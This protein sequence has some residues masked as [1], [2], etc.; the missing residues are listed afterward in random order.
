MKL[1]KKLQLLCTTLC[2]IAGLGIAVAQANAGTTTTTAEKGTLTPTKVGDI[3]LSVYDF[4]VNNLHIDTKT[5]NTRTTPYWYK[6]K[7]EKD[8][9]IRIDMSARYLKTQ[10]A[11]ASG[12]AILWTADATS[13]PKVSFRI[14]RDETAWYQVSDAYSA[15]GNTGSNMTTPIALDKGEYYLA[16]DISDPS[17]T[18]LGQKGTTGNV[19]MILYQQEINSDEVYRP[20]TINNVN[21]VVIDKEYTG[22][23]TASNPKDFY[24]FKLTEKA[25]VK[26]NCY[27]SATKHSGSS[28]NKVYFTLMDDKQEKLEQK[29]FSGDKQWYSSEKYLEPGTYYY[30]LETQSSYQSGSMGSA[31]YTDGGETRFKITTTSYPLTL[32]KVG[33]TKNTYVKVTTIDDAKEIRVVKGKLSN[34]DLESQKWGAAQIITDTKK[35]GVNKT[36]WYTVRVEDEYGNKFMNSIKISSCD[37]TAPA[38][39]KVNKYKAGALK[40]TG[41]AEKNATITVTANGVSFTCKASSKGKFTCKLTGAFS[42]GTK[43]TVT[44]TDISGNKSAKASFTV[45]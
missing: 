16:L 11:K 3:E 38:K 8:S 26:F 22:V 25:L 27:Y 41:T 20:S 37:K 4:N 2:L 15:Q 6:I 45:K 5:N 14:Y 24:S 10:S 43:V 42:S 1:R 34:S 9:L 7:L 35:F 32:K 30:T 28:S 13:N 39:P 44:A 31:E 33:T 18:A 29:D 12:S 17:C 21:T 23:L 19:E 40:V 36:G